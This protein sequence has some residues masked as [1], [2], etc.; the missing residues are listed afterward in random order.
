MENLIELETEGGVMHHFLPWLI[1][2]F[3]ILAAVID[4]AAIILLL[5]AFFSTIENRC[6]ELST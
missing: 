2:G 1:E 3:E 5:I 4:I 6:L